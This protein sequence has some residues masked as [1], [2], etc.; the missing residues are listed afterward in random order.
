MI[1]KEQD[2]IWNIF[3]KT[4]TVFVVCRVGGTFLFIFT[5]KNIFHKLCFDNFTTGLICLVI[6]VYVKMD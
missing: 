5:K 1:S 2:N 4:S 6:T 3:F